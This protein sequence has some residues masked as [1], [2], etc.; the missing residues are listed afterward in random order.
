MTAPYGSYWSDADDVDSPP[1]YHA[2][3]FAPELRPAPALPAGGHPIMARGRTLLAAHD[4][5]LI[6]VRYD[7]SCVVWASMRAIS[8]AVGWNVTETEARDLLVDA[9]S[10]PELRDDLEQDLLQTNAELAAAGAPLLADTD[11]LLDD[12]AMPNAHLNPILTARALERITG[13]GRIIVHTVDNTNDL[14]P[15]YASDGDAPF[16]CQLFYE[17]V[18]GHMALVLPLPRVAARRLPPPTNE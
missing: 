12:F 13:G 15:L 11:A 8:G 6:D 7:G 9:M 2:I 18:I 3:P 16:T 10:A 5:A 17:P 1:S 4:L 14:V